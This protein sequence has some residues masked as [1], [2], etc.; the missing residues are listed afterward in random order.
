LLLLVDLI[1]FI[2]FA[3]ENKWDW[4]VFKFDLII[5]VQTLSSSYNCDSKFYVIVSSIYHSC[6]KH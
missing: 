4:I 3:D 6:I 2:H 5:L 1:Y